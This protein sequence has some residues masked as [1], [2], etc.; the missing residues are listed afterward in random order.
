MR[1]IKA[2]N[3]DQDRLNIYW[4]L[5][6]WC[7]F[8]CT[9]CSKD[10]KSGSLVPFQPPIDD[11]L[12]FCRKLGE[13]REHGNKRIELNISGGEP[14]VHQGFAQILSNI[15]PM[16]HTI[17][18]TN[19]SRPTA[20][21]KT[22]PVL[23]DHSIFSIHAQSKLDR[24][25]ASAEY[26]ISEGKSVAFNCCMD[27]ND[28]DRAVNH[29]TLLSERFGHRA[30]KKMIN[31]LDAGGNYQTDPQVLTDEQAEF[32]RAPHAHHDP[33]PDNTRRC[34]ERNTAKLG[35]DKAEIVYEDGGSE[36]QS[37]GYARSAIT[38]NNHHHF[39]GWLCHAGMETFHVTPTGDVWAGICK[40]KK[41]C[42]IYDFSMATHP[43]ICRRTTCICPGD[44]TATKRNPWLQYI[45]HKYT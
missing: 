29:Y 41:L 31:D 35:S 24:I 27:A 39:K 34:L 21:W 45:G 15:H 11:L 7:N 40:M 19:G 17:V 36:I 5:T 1:K 12:A 16:I 25:I 23:P 30:R 38:R 28:W 2:I 32:M 42:T 9:Y 8:S 10:A 26:L 6:N 44:I 22:L 13:I 43:L 20:W 18:T 3:G 14:T 33:Y 37:T 4:N